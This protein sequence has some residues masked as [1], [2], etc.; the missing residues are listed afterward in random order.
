MQLAQS[1]LTQ[2]QHLA[3]DVINIRGQLNASDTD[4]R[5]V[6]TSIS[7]ITAAVDQILTSTQAVHDNVTMAT[8]DAI[9][10][11]AAWRNVTQLEADATNLDGQV[12]Y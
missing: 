11:S 9:D 8:S 6:S 2:Q 12:C 4:I 5:D 3:D 10:L 7:D 1:A